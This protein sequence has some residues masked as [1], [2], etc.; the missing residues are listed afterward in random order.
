M[1]RPRIPPTGIFLV[2]ISVARRPL[3]Q[4]PRESRSLQRIGRVD[5]SGDAAIAACRS[6]PSTLRAMQTP[7]L[8]Y[9]DAGAGEPVVLIHGLGGNANVWGAQRRALSRAFRVLCPD[10]PGC[11][12][13]RP[14][15][16]M[17]IRTLVDD[18][19][20]FLDRVGIAS[21]HFAG[22]SLG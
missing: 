3:R 1:T 11:G 14:A 8:E 12:R 9:D 22:H 5:K 10:L 2:A 4:T 21:A 6:S 18:I 7:H 20:A 13:S 16:D 15:H 19:V 17:S